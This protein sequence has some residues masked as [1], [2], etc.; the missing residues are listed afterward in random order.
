MNGVGKWI[1]RLVVALVVAVAAVA[2]NPNPAPAAPPVGCYD[3]PNVGECPPLDNF[4]CHT[5]CRL[6]GYYSGE[7]MSLGSGCCACF[8]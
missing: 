4:T 3:P 2:V 1:M 5:E 8:L 7:C 6:A